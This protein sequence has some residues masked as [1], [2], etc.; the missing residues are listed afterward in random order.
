MRILYF[1][2][3]QVSH[4]NLQYSLCGIVEHSGS[5]HGGHYVACVKTRT[6]DN[7]VKWYYISDSRVSEI[8]EE[9]VLRK[10]A[11]ILF[12]HQRE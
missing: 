4:D 12:Y 6:A 8:Q 5:L 9:A 3:I 2:A 7:R 11:Y 10:Q 1:S